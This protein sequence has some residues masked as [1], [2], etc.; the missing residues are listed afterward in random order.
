MEEGYLNEFPTAWAMTRMQGTADGRSAKELAAG[1]RILL[2][3]DPNLAA[4][5]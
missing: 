1:Q 2:K 5:G 3:Q 4:S